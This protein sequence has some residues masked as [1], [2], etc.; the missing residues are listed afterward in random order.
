MNAEAILANFDSSIEK[1][2]TAHAYLITGPLR[3]GTMLVAQDMARRILCEKDQQGCGKCASCRKVDGRSHPDYIWIEPR[4][5]SRQISIAEIRELQSMV[6]QTSYMGAW[7]VCVVAGA[8]RMAAPAANA[9][10][11]SLEEPPPRCIFILLAENPQY[12]LPTIISRCHR[13]ELTTQIDPSAYEWYGKL[14]DILQKSASGTVAR[15]AVSYG[16]VALLK[17]IKSGI[18]AMLQ[19]ED[20][21]SEDVDE[22]VMDARIMARYREERSAVM[23]MV[24]LWYRDIL[25]L[26]SGADDDS[27]YHRE[28]IEA[29]MRSSAGLS[30]RSATANIEIVEEMAQLLERHLGEDAV[31]LDGFSRLVEAA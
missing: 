13:L 9:L 16:L 3:G 1:Q 5:K 12:L 2:R 31:F 21:Y 23:R 17:D 19:E 15:M 6:H 11:K 8:D 4:M 28:Y 30:V 22:K 18:E 20:D 10:L 26:V 14:M 7:K 25:V 27:V 24:L 29:L